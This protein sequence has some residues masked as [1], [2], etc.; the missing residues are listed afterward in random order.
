MRKPEYRIPSVKEIQ[1]IKGSNGL[2]VVSFFSGG[3]GSC[4][5]FEMAGYKILS[6]SE[7]VEEARNTYIL[8]H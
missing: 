7:F 4:L 8:N 5:G 2:N 3:G 6:A 1:K